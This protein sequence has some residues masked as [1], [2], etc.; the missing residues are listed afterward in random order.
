VY[1]RQ[2]NQNDKGATA[3]IQLL[4]FT[5][6]V[7]MITGVCDAITGLEIIDYPPLTWVGSFLVTSSIAW[8]LVLHIGKLYEERRELG[9]RL[10]YDHLTQAFS[11]SYLEIRLTEAISLMSR[12]ELK[13][14]SVCVF[15]IDN[16]KKIN[17]RFG[18]ASGDEV[19]KKI[20][21]IVKENIRQLDCIA[22]LGGDEFVILLSEKK[23][24]NNA[25]SIVERIRRNI[26]ETLFSVDE[27]QFNA[28]CSFGIVSAK[29]EQLNISD[30]ANQM[31]SCADEALYNAKDKGKNAIAESTLTDL[32][33]HIN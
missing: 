7:W 5:N 26:S 4:L 22:R 28:S 10:M 33:L 1:V 27:R 18:H 2:R 3:T 31:L 17:D 13:I 11:R 24:E 25:L 6:I 29:P 8:V 30:F 15:D 32:S 19:L 9:N 23:E 12:D 21:Q 16:F 20:T 14:L